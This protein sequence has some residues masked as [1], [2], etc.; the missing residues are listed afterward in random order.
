MHLTNFSDRIWA[1]AIVLSRI[2]LGVCVILSCHCDE[3][4]DGCLSS[5][6]LHRGLTY[7]SEEFT[8]SIIRVKML[9]EREHGRVC[10]G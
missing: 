5:G 2:I 7:V 1:Y 9:K 4:E 8:V 3:Y 10:M 6:V